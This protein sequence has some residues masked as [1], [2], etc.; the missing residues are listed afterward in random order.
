MFKLPDG[1]YTLAIE[2]FPPTMDKVSVSVVSASLNIDQQSTK[3]FPKYSRSIVH[4]HKYDI[5]P[6]EDIYVDMEC[7][8][9]AGSPA[10]G[11]G[12]LIVYG[13]EGRQNDADSDVFDA[14]YV[15]EKGEMV[16]LSSAVSVGY[17]E[18]GLLKVRDKVNNE[19]FE[20]Y[21]DFRKPDSFNIVESGN[22][23]IFRV[24]KLL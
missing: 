20:S 14:L 15:L 11:V 2:F 7:Q 12:H 22:I 3:L 18:E 8:G 24:K 19:L 21:I 4:L 23:Q 1:E 13:I 9:T 17:L 10:Q 16:M 5:T 6:P